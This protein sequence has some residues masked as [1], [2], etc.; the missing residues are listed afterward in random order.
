MRTPQTPPTQGDMTSSRLCDGVDEFDAA[1]NKLKK[2]ES[3]FEK[4]LDAKRKQLD[5]NATQ[6]SDDFQLVNHQDSEIQGRKTMTK[7]Q[8]ECIQDA[9]SQ[10]ADAI[11]QIRTL[12]Q[13][14]TALKEQITQMEEDMEAAAQWIL[15]E[16]ALTRARKEVREDESSRMPIRSRPSR[17]GKR[18]SSKIIKAVSALNEKV[19]DD[20]QRYFDNLERAGW[21]SESIPAE[22]QKNAK[23]LLGKRLTSFLVKQSETR[24]VKY[25]VLMK[26]VIEVYL[27][28]WCFAIIEGLYPKQ[29]S[30]EDLLLDLSALHLGHKNVDLKCP[31]NIIQMKSH[32]PDFDEWV[33]DLLQELELILAVGDVRLQ[34]E[35]SA[36]GTLR[37]LIKSAYDLRRALAERDLHGNI[38]LTMPVPNTVFKP[39]RMD[40]APLQ[41]VPGWVRLLRS[42]NP[43]E[44]NRVA[45]TSSLGITCEGDDGTKEIIVKP[46][47]TSYTV[48]ED[49][50]SLRN[51]RSGVHDSL[52]NY[53]RSRSLR[54]WPESER[55]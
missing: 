10:L 41:R 46:V 33:S 1:A 5:I 35:D 48:I 36:P 45:G 2:I 52:Y 23:R 9:H 22:L 12:R 34:S 3:T 43:G 49:E 24:D 8:L 29:R 39:E 6:E 37:R 53:H 15:A 55:I 38:K 26:T 28:H 17:L 25:P 47:V 7:S 27:F 11:H 44:A 51:M 54:D 40:E 21:Q 14:N 20:A 42:T 31:Q 4:L 32:R 50:I 30:F 18:P 19:Q 13:Q 16:D